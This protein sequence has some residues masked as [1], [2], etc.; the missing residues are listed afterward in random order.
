MT[1]CSSSS[2]R[3][4]C[5]GSFGNASRAALVSIAFAIACLGTVIGV[6]TAGVLVN[7][8]LAPVLGDETW[9]L[10]GQFT[11][12]YTGGGA[13]FAAL[14]AAFETSPDLFAAATADNEYLHV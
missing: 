2:S 10:A 5:S 11:G 6:L 9:K 13:N 4:A 1:C 8:Q 14:G 12:T 7:S 3:P